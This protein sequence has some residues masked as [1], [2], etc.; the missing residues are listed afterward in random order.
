[1]ATGGGGGGGGARQ[2]RRKAGLAGLCWKTCYFPILFWVVTVCGEEKTLI[3]ETWL[4][5][6]GYLLPHDL[7][8]SDLRQEKAMQSAVAAMQRF[9]GIPVT[10]IL[11][12]TT[13]EW[14]RRP[15]CG[16]PDHPHTT[17]RQRNKRYALTG[18]K[19]RDKK[20]SYSISNFTPKVGEKDTQRA[21]RQAFNVWQTVTPLSFQEVPYSEIKNDGKEAD[22][23]IFFASG[24]HGDS[25]PFDGEGGFL[26]HAYFPGA[27]IGG[28]THFDSDEPWT[29]GNANHD[30]ETTSSRH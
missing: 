23:M 4:K 15:R 29:L 19:W 6:Y 11:D 22:I 25:S 8:T 30:G 12:E 21:I 13:I 28:D 27:G 1:M 17:R 20:I 9:Y 10:G 5:N 3:V 18:Q 14:M 2:R 7:R 26:A 24:F 16:V